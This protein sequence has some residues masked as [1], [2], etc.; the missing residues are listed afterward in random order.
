ME[1]HVMGKISSRPENKKL[2]FDFRFQG[3]RC[4]EQTLLPDNKLNRKRLESI[5]NKIEAE[6]TL[7]VFNYADYFPNSKMVKVF[8]SLKEIRKS[9]DNKDESPLFSEFSQI[10]LD[11]MQVEWRRS[12]F[13]ANKGI[14]DKYL[15]PRF[16]TIHVSQIQR[17]AYYNLRKELAQLPGRN[18][19]TLSVSRINHTMSTFRNIILEA[20]ERYKFTY[21]FK[22]IKLLRT[23]R[24][25]VV[26]FS[27]KE[28][29][30]ILDKVRNDFNA[31]YT[32]RFFTGMRT[33]EIDGL[34]W[35][36]INFDKRLILIREAIVDGV[37]GDVKNEFSIRDIH[38]SE[39]VFL[40]LV[41][42]RKRTAQYDFVFTN[43]KGNPL[44]HKNVTK[45]VWYPILR[46][47]NLLKRTPYQTRHT[48]ATIW[49]AS[50]EAPEWIARQMGHSTTTM[51]FKVYSQHVPN[52][53]RTDGTSMELL[54]EQTV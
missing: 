25:K 3:K 43:S 49:L 16:A 5:L 17:Q 26:P 15:L 1:E 8:T 39:P 32:V 22:D 35:K 19:T 45:R 38:M 33:G 54:L 10:W 12:N 40:A 29:K 20:S 42:Q 48:T 24:T 18:N 11:E 9:Y 46:H 47:L 37:M 53:L 34:K 31:Y 6:I 30:L 21:P 44:D 13:V 52:L 41:E 27:L 36:Y 23:P 50:G 14:I 4:R 2:F 28:V 51:L 7:N